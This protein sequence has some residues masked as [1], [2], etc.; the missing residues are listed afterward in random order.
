V[1]RWRL[2]PFVLF[3]GG[4][5]GQTAQ[6]ALNPDRLVYEAV[7]AFQAS[8]RSTKL[9]T[10]PAPLGAAIPDESRCSIPLAEAKI[11]K[12]VEFTMKTVPPPTNFHSNMPVARG[13]PACS[14][15]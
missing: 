12:E 2:V 15:K 1:T 3:A 14:V 4:A 11:Q 13:L 8:Q 10:N 5:L 9:V 7:L 6:D